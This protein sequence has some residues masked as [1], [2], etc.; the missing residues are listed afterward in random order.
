MHLAAF[1]PYAE[2]VRVQSFTAQWQNMLPVLSQVGNGQQWNP[3]TVTQATN[4]CWGLAHAR[5]CTGALP[6]ILKGVDTSSTQLK[7]QQV[8]TLLWSCAI[9]SHQPTTIL[10]SLAE[11]YTEQ[12]EGASIC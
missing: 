3:L 7:P 6:D 2:Q 10:A 8:T 1:W 11:H 9:L 12:P 4:C 5:H